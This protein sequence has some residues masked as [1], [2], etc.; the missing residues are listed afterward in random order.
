MSAE[1][2]PCLEPGCDAS[3]PSRRSRSVHTRFHPWDPDATEKA[4][5]SCDRRKPLDAFCIDKHRPDNRRTQCRSCDNA[6]Q[7]GRRAAEVPRSRT[8]PRVNESPLADWKAEAPCR[9]LDPSL[10][11]PEMGES[12]AAAIAVCR[13]C[14]FIDPCR[15]QALANHEQG[16]WG[17]TTD[18]DRQKLRRSRRWAS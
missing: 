12:P 6:Y 14:P 5:Y 4:C 7:N 1:T 10:F 8:V 9:G 11:Y 3:F 16:V 2:Y 17:G 13:T 18:R 15:D